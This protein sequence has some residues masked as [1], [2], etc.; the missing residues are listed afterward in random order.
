MRR[1]TS[2]REEDQHPAGLQLLVHLLQRRFSGAAMN[3]IYR[4]KQRA[5]GLK[6]GEHAVGDHFD[7]AAHAGYR[8][9]ERQAVEGAGG[10]VGDND[11]RAIFGDLF[12]I[13][14][15]DGAADIEVFA[16]PVRPYQAPSGGGDGRQIVETLP[17]KIAFFNSFFLPGARPRLRPQ[18]I[19][20]VVETKHSGSSSVLP[21]HVEGGD[22]VQITVG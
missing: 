4:D 8:I 1:E 21:R 5:Q 11:Q 2:R 7:I 15:R 22:V 19:E 6:V 16:A 14:R 20:Y 18:V 12:E 13:V 3:I 17:H 9:Q 10:V